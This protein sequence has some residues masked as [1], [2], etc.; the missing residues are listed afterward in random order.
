[1]R[2]KN[3]KSWLAIITNRLRPVRLPQVPDHEGDRRSEPLLDLRCDIHTHAHAQDNLSVCRTTSYNKIAQPEVC[4][5]C[6][7]GGMGMNVTA[8]DLLLEVLA[9]RGEVDRGRQAW[10]IILSVYVVY[11]V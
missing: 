3:A 10:L 2:R 1:M 8:R 6:S 9:E 4:G 11:I 7:G 5:T